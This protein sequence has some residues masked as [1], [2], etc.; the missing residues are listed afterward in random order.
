MRR[1]SEAGF[2]LLA[3]AF[4][5]LVSGPAFA[6]VGSGG[7]AYREVLGLDSRTLVWVVAQLHL[8]FGAFVLGVP[9]FA[10]IVESV[11]VI[12]GDERYD[13]LA[14]EFTK[15]LSA[16]FSTTAA[17]G[18]TLAFLLIGLYPRFMSVLGDAL[19][20]SF[21]VYAGLFFV[22]A[23]TLYLYYYGW[24]RLKGRTANLAGAIRPGWILTALLGVAVIGL[25]L[26]HG[27]DIRALREHGEEAATQIEAIAEALGENV[28]SA[29]ADGEVGALT[30]EGVWAEHI[31]DAVAAAGGSEAARQAGALLLPIVVDTLRNSRSEAVASTL[32]RKE[33]ATAD[34]ARLDAFNRG[35]SASAAHWSTVGIVALAFLLCM[36]FASYATSSK[37]FHLYLGLVLNVAGIAVMMIANSWATYMMSP[38]G[39]NATTL[40]FGG[41]TWGSMTNPLWNPLNLHRLLANIVFGGFV[42]GSY[43]A[44]RFL[45]SSTPEQR[46][47]Y[48]WMGYIG[49]FVGI[50][51]MIPL[52]FA[53]YYLGREVYSFSP[54]MGNNM[55]GGAFSWAFIFQ[56]V[57]I[58]ILFIGANYYLWI[59]MGRIPGSERYAKFIPW[60]SVVLMIC[61]AI[62][63]TPHNLPLSGEERALMGGVQYHPLLK[64]LGL[65]PAKN[66]VV[67]LII[68]TT[69]LCFL[70]YRRANKGETQPFASHGAVARVVLFGALG[71]V[72]G[73]LGWYT[74]VILGMDLSEISV[75]E[76]K[77]WVLTA[78]AGALM[79]EMAAAVVA[80]F[81]ALRDRG[82]L[83]QALYFAVTAVIVTGFLGVWGFVTMINANPF[84][85][86][87]AVC[88]VLM[89]LSAMI[90]NGTIDIFLFRGAKEVGGIR[91]GE[92]PAR[93]QF[94]LVV[95]TVAVVQLMCLM[96]FIRSGLREDWHI[97]GVMRDTSAG[98]GTPTLAE[99]GWIAGWITLG[100]FA[101]VAFVFWL[102]GLSDKGEKTDSDVDRSEK[103]GVEKETGTE[104]AIP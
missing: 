22:E 47:H 88:Q 70:M 39:V 92:M 99:M 65:M 67:N 83:G 28:K 50:L 61:F 48:D 15:L 43:A 59:G 4:G 42:A 87:I 9:I 68:L 80:A 49:N 74:L 2:V 8:L 81:L 52:P 102:A 7:T 20:G 53:G 98:A 97:Y 17:L 95:I 27:E 14:R 30:N 76:E 54:I 29:L 21:Y 24:D 84:L 57:L 37:G 40:E 44:I 91:W 82:K 89:V 86:N 96:G 85:R 78:T 94:T 56:A 62:W 16:A 13:R 66:A 19:H 31:D 100:F 60:Y 11:A 6:A 90:L 69:F 45:G 32:A 18:G 46:A 64:Y 10:V 79:M 25:M 3:V 58:G 12:G 26:F 55:M 103:M 1:G 5:C 77:R 41:T 93:A 101:L 51:A 36:G 104:G 71:V 23:F 38:T 75:P 73:I 72:L 34:Q 63:V 35:S 33:R